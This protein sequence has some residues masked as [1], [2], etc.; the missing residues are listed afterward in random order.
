MLQA[1]EQKAEHVLARRRFVHMNQG[2]IEAFPDTLER[3]GFTD[4][5]SVLALNRQTRKG[6]KKEKK[7]KQ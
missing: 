1:A 6:K 2:P 5:G 3:R 7:K 4:A